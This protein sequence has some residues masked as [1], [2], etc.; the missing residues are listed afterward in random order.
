VARAT[1]RESFDMYPILL[2]A[3]VAASASA[4]PARA[5]RTYTVAVDRADLDLTRARDVAR[6]DR[7]IARAAETACGAPSPYDLA[8]TN[9]QP[10]CT[11]AAIAATAITRDLAIAAARAARGQ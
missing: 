11:R 9:D 1:R 4:L 3:A 6:L 2:I 10:R 5:Q 7:R 8:G